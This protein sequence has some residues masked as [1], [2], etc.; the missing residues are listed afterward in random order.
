MKWIKEDDLRLSKFIEH[1]NSQ[2]AYHF[3]HSNKRG[4]TKI[5]GINERISFHNILSNIQFVTG[6]GKK[7]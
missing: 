1:S 5:I 6:S 4:K 7:V 3:R 2:N